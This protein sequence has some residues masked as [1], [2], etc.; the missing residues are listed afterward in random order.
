M[1][2]RILLGSLFV[3]L[4]GNTATAPTIRDSSAIASGGC[5]VDVGTI[6]TVP[7]EIFEAQDDGPANLPRATAQ[8]ELSSA[9]YAG[10]W[11]TLPGWQNA[12][13][14][15]NPGVYVC[16]LS[17]GDFSATRGHIVALVQIGRPT[18]QRLFWVWV[19]KRGLD[20]TGKLNNSWRVMTIAFGDHTKRNKVAFDSLPSNAWPVS[21]SAI[22]GIWQWISQGT[23]GFDRI[24]VMIGTEFFLATKEAIQK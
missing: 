22:P 20:G 21:A 7:V 10:P 23:T 3:S 5:N 18:A 14:F 11:S 9:S 2:S 19:D 16:R 4:L 1:I 12:A 17:A 15:V 24:Q 8:S 6:P 13:G